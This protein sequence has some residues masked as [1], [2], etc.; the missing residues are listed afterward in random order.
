MP[1]RMRRGEGR[2]PA[3][4]PLEFD[5]PP[6]TVAYMVR[7][8]AP[9]PGLDRAGGVPPLRAIWR[10]HRIDAR[11]LAEFLRLTGLRADH[12]VPILYPHVF[13]FRLQMVI[14]TH[15]AFPLP[16][17]RALQ[18]RNHLLQHRSVP[19]DAVLDLETG[20]AAQ[21]ILDKGAEVDLHTWVRRDGELVWESRNTFYY[22]GRFGEAGPPSALAQAPAVGDALAARW[23]M[24]RGVGWRFGRL[25]GDYNGI[26]W[27]GAYARRLGFR[28]AFQHPQLS[29]GQSLARLPAPGPGTVQ[30]LDAWLKGPVYYDADVSLRTAAEVDGVTF[31]LIP[32]RE[33]RPAIVGRWSAGPQ[34]AGWP[35]NSD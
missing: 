21:R 10:R 3:S 4:P 28:G 11:H 22:R 8:L 12:G 33:E 2:G 9:S 1:A 30:R 20:I 26:H 13:G 27:W 29:L 7:G 6:S 18:I 31:A 35:T 15:P 16:I 17:W 19:P 23:R 24:T 25:T 34:A 32:D 14:V 5:R